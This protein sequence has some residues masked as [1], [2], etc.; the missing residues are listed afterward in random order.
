MKRVFSAKLIERSLVYTHRIDIMGNGIQEHPKL[1]FRHFLTTLLAVIAINTLIAL[2]LTAIGFGL[3]PVPAFIF[4]QCIGTSIY[5]CN[6]AAVPL[7]RKVRGLSAQIAVIAASVIVGA[8]AGTLL[9]AFANGMNPLSFIREHSV[10]FSQSILIGLL[11]GSIVIYIFISLEALSREK[12][13]RL[14]MEKITAETELK[15]LHSQMEPHFLFNTLSNIISLIDTDHEKSRRMLESFT[16]FLRASLLT[17]RERTISL[18]QEL[19]VI[20][21]YLDVFTVRMGDRLN[22]VI[23][24]PQSIRGCRIPPLLVQP[25]VENAVK[26]GLEPSIHGGTVA[27][28]GVRDGD[29]I[30][31]T[32]SDSGVG[33]NEKSSGGGV[34]I[35]NIR[36]RLELLYGHKEWLRFEENISGGMKATVEIPY[37]T[38]TRDHS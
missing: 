26:H 13:K 18:S 19:D 28:Q 7:C 5:L 3:G 33:I 30:R 6:L 29:I 16:A 14:E 4:S 10:L 27:I 32:V 12:V 34:G 25:L 11:F 31:I 38:G 22:Y 8:A 9:G 21:N 24:I 1:T 2:I 15:L 20:R 36:R 35:E 23:D 17:S 37:E